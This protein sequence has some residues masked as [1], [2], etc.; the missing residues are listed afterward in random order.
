MNILDNEAGLDGHDQ[1]AALMKANIH[2]PIGATLDFTPVELKV[3]CHR[4]FSIPNR[5]FAGGLGGT[6]LRFARSNTTT[7]LVEVCF[8]SGNIYH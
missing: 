6:D 7:S 3:A 5:A 4:A 2:Q 1:L 8:V